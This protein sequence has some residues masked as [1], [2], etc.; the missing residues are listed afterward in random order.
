VVRRDRAMV[1]HAHLNPVRLNL[2]AAQKIGKWN[3]LFQVEA[4]M[5]PL[6]SA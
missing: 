3:R 4:D 2:K 5:G 1:D 6:T